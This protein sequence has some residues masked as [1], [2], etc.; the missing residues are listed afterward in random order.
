MPLSRVSAVVLAA[1]ASKRFSGK[2]SKL[3]TKVGGKEMVRFPLELLDSLNLRKTFVLGH[4]KDKV[5]E[6]IGQHAKH[7]VHFAFQHEQRGTGHAL[8]CA[9]KEWPFCG[10][11]VLNADMPLVT[12]S[13]VKKLVSHHFES[14]SAVSFV[15]F[16]AADPAEYGRVFSDGDKV[17][18]VEAKDCSDE[19]K[20][21]TLVNAGIYVFE[22]VFLTESVEKLSDQNAS[23]EFYLTEL[24]EIASSKGLKV[25]VIDAPE[26]ECLGVNTLDEL[27]RAEKVLTEEQENQLQG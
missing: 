22:K 9:K 14:G 24:V 1:G 16:N 25:S 20:K 4:E 13:L 7:P 2:D 27:E 23:G 17:K 5:A 11:L 19:Q 12:P 26:Q 6:L 10:V 21:N 18:I 8:A 3:L 15:A